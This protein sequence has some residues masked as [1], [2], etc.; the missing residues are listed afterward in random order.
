MR[1]NTIAI[2]CGILSLAA[3]SGA[4]AQA[5][6][7]IDLPG[8]TGQIAQVGGISAHN[9]IA[10]FYWRNDG[11]KP[12][13]VR[14]SDG[15]VTTFVP[16]DG[17]QTIVTGI[18][19]KDAVVGYTFGGG[20]PA[21][22]RSADGTTVTFNVSST[23]VAACINDKGQVAGTYQNGRT[24]DGFVRDADGTV[25]VFPA[26]DGTSFNL[27]AINN[28]GIVAGNYHASTHGF[29]RSRKGTIT[30]FDIP[31]ASAVFVRGLT[32]GGVIAGYYADSSRANHGYIRQADGS[33]ET[34]DGP[35]AD[36]TYVMGANED[37]IVVGYYTQGG[38]AHGFARSPSGAFATLDAPLG[39]ISTQ[40]YDVAND[41]KM[42]G[43]Y[44]DAGGSPHVTRAN[45][46]VTGF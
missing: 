21:F 31:G 4:H 27:G 29:L 9:T 2:L 45:A 40:L 15:K 11:T 36:S 18:N 42:V 13:F 41:G 16:V 46:A 3:A 38:V 44:Y 28:K 43:V 8:S 20:N 12:G 32:N 30:T 6:L 19:N 33:V 24:F 37:G 17:A 1:K 14:T 35:D 7:T 22:V 23:T 10:G 26:P 5:W 25:H 39:E 34:F